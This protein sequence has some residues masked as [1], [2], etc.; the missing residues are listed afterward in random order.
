MLHECINN[1]VESTIEH[2]GGG[3]Y[4]YKLAPQLSAILFHTNAI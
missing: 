4:F 1:T 2:V 3:V